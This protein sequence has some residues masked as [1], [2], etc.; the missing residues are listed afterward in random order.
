MVAWLVKRIRLNGWNEWNLS[1]RNPYPLV[2][3]VS[4]TPSVLPSLISSTTGTRLGATTGTRPHPRRAA[5]LRGARRAAHTRGARRVP[6]FAQF[7]LVPGTTP[8]TLAAPAFAQGR[9][10]LAGPPAHIMIPDQAGRQ[11]GG[12]AG[13][14]AGRRIL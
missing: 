12:Q 6:A 13:R 2:A 1:T 10:R 7:R 14:Q 8:H 11:A 3:L 5:H 9:T 4:S